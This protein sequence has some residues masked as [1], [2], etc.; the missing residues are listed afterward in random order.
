MKTKIKSSF[1]INTDLES[2][3]VPEDNGKQNPE[4]SYTSKYKKHVACNYGYK[5]VCDDDKISESF[6]SNLGEYSVYNFIDSMVEK[7]KYC[8]EEMKKYFN[9]KFVITKEDDDED[10][11]SPTKCW[12]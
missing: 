9:K 11:E 12:I 5:L 2:I 7:D 6:K 1:I 3:L 4:E 10:F 8:K